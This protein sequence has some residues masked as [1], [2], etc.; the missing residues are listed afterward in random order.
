VAQAHPLSQQMAT[1]SKDAPARRGGFLGLLRCP[2]RP[3]SAGSF[4][5]KSISKR[6][7]IA[8]GE[9]A[10]AQASPNPAPEEEASP[11][12]ELAAATSPPASAKEGDDGCTQ[13]HAASNPVPEEESAPRAKVAATSPSTSADDG[14]AIY[15]PAPEEEAVPLT[16]V[17]AAMSPPTSADKRDQPQ[18]HD[19]AQG[20]GQL[21]QPHKAPKQLDE[22]AESPRRRL[23][24]KGKHPAVQHAAHVPAATNSRADTPTR[25]ATRAAGYCKQ[26]SRHG[27]VLDGAHEKKGGRGASRKRTAAD[28]GLGQGP[29]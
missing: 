16:E 27:H 28:V 1:A 2:V 20:S 12:P 19:V 3:R 26:P 11:P 5:Q 23:S 18:S 13:G 4:I 24:V 6:Q 22:V 8:T 21:G 9:P 10:E 15:N 25:G 7:R 17:V 14:Q 29:A